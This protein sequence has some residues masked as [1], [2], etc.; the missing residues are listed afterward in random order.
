MSKEGAGKKPTE[1]E[2]LI[3]N[4]VW[5]LGSATVREVFQKLE[6]EHQM[7]YT[8][9]LK[10]M[11]IMRDKGLLECDTSVKPQVFTASRPRQQMQKLLLRDLV[12]KA[13][14]GSPGNLVLQALSV[15]KS[16]P[17]ELQQIRAMLDKL[18]KEE[19]Q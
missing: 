14:D 17:E 12:D 6:A 10:L 8:T 1:T 15:R 18:Q 19:G 16:T 13:F 11:Q 5:G 4:T 9:V 2:L 3:L 7:G